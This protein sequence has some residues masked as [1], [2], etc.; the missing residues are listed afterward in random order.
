MLYY[1][2]IACSHMSGPVS[3]YLQFYVSKFKELSDLIVEVH[4]T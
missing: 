4:L 2:G 1:N 3:L